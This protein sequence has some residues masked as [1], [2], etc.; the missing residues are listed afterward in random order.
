MPAAS[1]TAASGLADENRPPPPTPGSRKRGAAR[2]LFEEMHRPRLNPLAPLVAAGVPSATA[3]P[4]PS[5]RRI[6]GPSSRAS[7]NITTAARQH[8]RGCARPSTPARSSFSFYSA[9]PETSAAAIDSWAA[10]PCP[11]PVPFS[12]LRTSPPG[13]TEG[14]GRPPNPFCFQG[15][16]SALPDRR[17]AKIPAAVVKPAPPPPARKVVVVKKGAAVMGGSKAAGKQED[18]QKL[19]ILHNRYMQYRFLNAQAE[20]VAITKK[21]VAEV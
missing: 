7:P 6:L 10:A 13:I 12:E 15:L 2:D 18:V 5:P 3:T 9:S 1:T 17:R 4:G 21:A 8:R 19:R 20:A 11:R 14:P 16:A